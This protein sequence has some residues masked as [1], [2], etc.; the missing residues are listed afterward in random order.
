MSDRVTV[1]KLGKMQGPCHIS[2]TTEDELTRRT[3]GESV[4]EYMERPAV[5]SDK[6]AIK[7]SHLIPKGLEKKSPKAGLSFTLRQGE[8]LGLAGVSGNGQSELIA[9]LT[10]LAPPASG[11]IIILGEDM[12]KRSPRA[13]IEKGVAHIP[14]RRRQMGIVEQM[15]VAE[16]VV[17]KDYRQTPFSRNTVLNH[18]EITTHAQDI[19]SRFNALVPDLWDTECRILSGGNIQR[20][21][22]GRETWRKPPVIIASHPTEGLDAKAIRHTW[23]LFLELREQGSGILLIS[24]DL[25]EIMSLSDRIGVMSEG[26]IVGVVEGQ[27]ADRELL[28][29]WM[30]GTGAEAA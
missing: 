30:T 24:E 8:I 1:L 27:D 15:F 18:H 4:P 17:L 23:D 12:T 7:V 11:Q 29:H 25:D 26:A 19:V 16:N 3:F 5:R 22:L 2:E 20:L 6:P 28:G 9:S 21:I 14:E 13:F 10:G